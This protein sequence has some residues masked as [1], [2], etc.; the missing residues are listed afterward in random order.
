M[1]IQL[2]GVKVSRLVTFHSQ[3][4]ASRQSV[5]SFGSVKVQVDPVQAKAE[6]LLSSPLVETRDCQE[7]Q[8]VAVRIGG[9]VDVTGY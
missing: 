3:V 1:S 4:P 6:H 8:P 5:P 2:L 9:S 7:L